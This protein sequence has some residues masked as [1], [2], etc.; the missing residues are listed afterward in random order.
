MNEPKKL[1]PT[2]PS[3]YNKHVYKTKCKVCNRMAKDIHH[4]RFQS[5]ADENG[6]IDHFHKNS[7][8]NLVDLC[9]HCHQAVHSNKLTIHSYSQTSSGVKLIFEH[10]TQTENDLNPN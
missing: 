2:F 8:F 9:E 7:K 1:V 5:D 6:R 10:C 4:I 3:K